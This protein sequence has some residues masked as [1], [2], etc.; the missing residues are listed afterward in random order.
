MEWWDKMF[1]MGQREVL[2][3]QVSVAPLVYNVLSLFFE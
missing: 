2:S 1:M 3:R